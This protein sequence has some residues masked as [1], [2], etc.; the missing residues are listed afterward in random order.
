MGKWQKWWC[1][2]VIATYSHYL[3]LRYHHVLRF[4]ICPNFIF[5][6]CPIYLRKALNIRGKNKNML[7]KHNH[8]VHNLELNPNTC[9]A[10]IQQA[11]F[12]M[13]S[14]AVLP[15]VSQISMAASIALRWQDGNPPAYGQGHCTIWLRFRP[16]FIKDTFCPWT[17]MHTWSFYWVGDGP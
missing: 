7:P 13:S 8:C 9:L 1:T 15:W 4:D 17:K 16:Y 12:S 5:V 10:G 2:L 14:L 6:V 11:D 3:T